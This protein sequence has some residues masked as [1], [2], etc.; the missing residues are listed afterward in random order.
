MDARHPRK[1]VAIVSGEHRLP[2]CNVLVVDG[3]DIPFAGQELEGKTSCDLPEAQIVTHALLRI[4]REELEHGIHRRH[5]ERI[6]LY[7]REHGVFGA[8]VGRQRTPIDR[9]Q[10]QGNGLGLPLQQRNALVQFLCIQ[11]KGMVFVQVFGPQVKGASTRFRT[12]DTMKHRQ[13]STSNGEKIYSREREHR[14]EDRYMDDPYDIP[15]KGVHLQ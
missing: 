12:P 9:G 10:E 1:P 13:A 8:L 11:T 6:D 2:E 15:L 3:R 14:C 7:G 4:Q 5:A